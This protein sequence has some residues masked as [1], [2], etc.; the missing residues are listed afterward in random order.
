MIRKG[1]IIVA[2]D[3]ELRDMY[4]CE[5]I[6]DGQEYAERLLCRVLYMIAYPIQHDAHDSSIPRENMPLHANAIY[7][8][9][10]TRRASGEGDCYSDYEA[11]FD[12]CLREY[13]ARRQYVFDSQK[14][15]SPA[16]RHVPQPNPE[17]FEIL[18]RHAQRE[19]RT[20][21]TLKG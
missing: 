21:R 12:K 4:C 3:P 20:S 6:A 9:Q 2:I 14:D 18:K 1:E 10:F 5:V 13:E 15:T 19:F 16:C 8:L 7:R 11:S 17:E